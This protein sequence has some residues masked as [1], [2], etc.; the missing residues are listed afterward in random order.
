MR[1]KGFLNALAIGILIFLVID[2]FSHGWESA[3]NVAAGA[4]SGQ[5]PLSEAV[6]DLLAVF[7]G[8]AIGLLGLVW[9][10]NRYMMKERMPALAN[11]A[12]SPSETLILERR[13]AY[14]FAM[15]IAIGI[16]AHNFSERLKLIVNL[17]EPCGSKLVNL[18]LHK[19]HLRAA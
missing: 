16:G 9:Y 17:T 12:G 18:W 6:M 19:S 13:D 11:V 14:R 10:E 7:G 3:A 4:F 1:K 15:M 8:L 5:L 2:V